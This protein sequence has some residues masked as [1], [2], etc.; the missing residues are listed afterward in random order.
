MVVPSRNPAVIV[1]R[2]PCS[3]RESARFVADALLRS[4]RVMPMPDV[5]SR[6][7][8]LPVRQAGR[9][10]AVLAVALAAGHLAQ[11]LATKKSPAQKLSVLNSPVNVVQLS[12]APEDGG[13]IAPVLTADQASPLLSTPMPLAMVGDCT[14]TLHLAEGEGA[15]IAVSLTAPCDGGARVE[16]HHA[17]L[18]VTERISASGK[19]EA[20]VP[21][22]D[23]A[24]LLEVRFGDGR[25]V[26][27]AQ[28]MPQLAALR[29]FAVEWTGA[30]GFILH[31][32]E[33]GAEFG[34]K[35]DISPSQ[36]GMIPT[37]AT[38]GG[39]LSLLGDASVENPK[40][41]QIYTFPLTDDADVVVE[42]PVTAAN[43][44]QSVAGKT[45]TSLAGV[46]Q[47]TNLTLTMPDCSAV[48][49]FLVLNNLSQ[50]TKVA[51]R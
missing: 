23:Q 37:G 32:I 50:N 35:G 11:T 25:S 1:A 14:P 8:V 33:N 28:A 51:A 17:G 6:L 34:A 46:A 29:R 21:V 43:C 27:A 5:R 9:F 48:G 13:V 39:W 49:D 30:Q 15:M 18:T 10:L 44:A 42:A 24:G 31:G 47:A 26:S 20:R 36:P 16:L 2:F 12:A 41:A 3:G 22:L 40:L 45:L 19:M 7:S 38:Q 4:L